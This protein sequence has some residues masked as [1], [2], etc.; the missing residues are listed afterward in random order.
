MISVIIP[1]YKNRGQFLANLKHNLQYLKSLEI[2]VVN[3]NPEQSLKDT[4]DS[5]KVVLIENRGNLGFGES[6][7]KGVEKATRPYIMLLNDDVLL[8]DDSF[9]KAKSHFKNKKVF[10]VGFAQ[11]EKDGNIV[12][13][14]SIFW[15][16][17]LVLHKKAADTSFGENGWAEGGACLIDKKKFQEL[18]GFDPL[19]SPF[20][21]EDIDLSY[22]ARRAGYT[23]IFD[24]GIVVEHHHES[25]IG[26]YFS[27]DFVKTIAFRNQFLFMWKNATIKEKL[28][29]FLFLPFNICYYLL[30]GEFAFVKGFLLAATKFR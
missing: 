13:K 19:Y 24:P 15:E 10:A 22:R 16:R 25:T 7:N 1:T 2:I 20:Y 9:L 4:I 26:K 11:K 3:D 8:Q 6:V 5:S 12:G 30:K 21:W 27:S 18:G 29:H 28:T 14:N 23:I 17:G